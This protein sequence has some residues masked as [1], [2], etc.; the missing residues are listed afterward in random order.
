MTPCCNWLSGSPYRRIVSPSRRAA[1][2]SSCSRFSVLTAPGP[3]EPWAQRLQRLLRPPA[4]L[5]DRRDPALVLDHP[6]QPA[7]RRHG[8]CVKADQ[9]GHAD[10][11]VRDRGEDEARNTHVT[12]KH[13]AAIDL[14][15]QV[16]PG[17]QRVDA[18][19]L[20]ADRPFG[21]RIGAQRR[22]IGR[23]HRRGFFCQIAEAQRLLAMNCTSPPSTSHCSQPTFQRAAAAIAS[24]ARAAAAASRAGSS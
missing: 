10:G 5:R 8:P 24:M 1:C 7:K 18:V 21:G 19:V 2:V 14:G 6:D 3:A 20:L 13:H 16:E 17:E 15:W 12:C 11:T 9:L 23:V 4:S 22:G